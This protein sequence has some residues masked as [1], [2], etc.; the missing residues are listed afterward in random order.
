MSKSSQDVFKYLVLSDQQCKTQRYSVFKDLN[1][2]KQQIL[3]D[4]V[5]YF[6]LMNDFL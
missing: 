1:G 3:T 2:E 4:D 5:C 6:T